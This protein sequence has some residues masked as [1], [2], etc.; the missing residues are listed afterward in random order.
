MCAQKRSSF[1]VP[2]AMYASKTNFENFHLIQKRI[3]FCCLCASLNAITKK[4]NDMFLFFYIRFLGLTEHVYSNFPFVMSVGDRCFEEKHVYIASKAIE[5]AACKYHQ[6][7]FQSM[8][9]FLIELFSFLEKKILIF[10]CDF[11]LQ[12][13]NVIKN[14]YQMLHL[15]VDL[16]K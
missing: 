15:I 4:K 11:F 10:L 8:I 16:V 3:Y 9:S 6:M 12:D 7:I 13:T 14:V 2:N 1:S 5:N